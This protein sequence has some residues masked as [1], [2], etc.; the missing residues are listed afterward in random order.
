M[1]FPKQLKPID[2]PE[3]EAVKE[4]VPVEMYTISGFKEADID[5]YLRNKAQDELIKKVAEYSRRDPSILIKE[6][7]A[8][9]SPE[10]WIKA[11]GMIDS[12]PKEER[13]LL[14]IEV[15][16]KIK[17]SFAKDS[18]EVW[19]KAA[20]MINWA[21]I[22]ERASLRRDV[23]EKIKESFAK[24]NPEVWIEAIGMI[25]SAPK[26]ERA[27]LRRDVSEKIKESFSKDNPEVWIK[28]AEMINRAPEE[29]RA[30]LIKESFAKDSPEV[31]IKAAGIIYSAPEEERA[32]LIRESFA[33]DSPD[34][35]IKAAGMI[36]WAPIEERASLIRESFAK[37]SPEV[38]IK[39]A[40]MIN[41][42]P[43]EER[44]LLIKESFAK[45]SPEVWIKAAGMIDW[46]P[47]EEQSSLRRDVSEKI[48]ES[49]SKDSPELWI[50]AAGMI[51]LA[52]I[53]ERASLIREVFEKGIVEEIIKPPLY[54]NSN[55][56]DETFKREKFD[57][58]GSGTTLIGG[59]LKDKIITRHIE[60]EAFLSWQRLYEDYNL[61]KKNGFD[62]VPIEP[63]QS[64]KI[65]KDNLVD[66]HS[67]VL[68]LSLG[69]W[70]NITSLFEQELDTQKMLILET[71]ESVDIEHGHAHNDN[72]VL[73]FFRDENGK[74]DITK[75]PRLYLIDFDQAVSPEK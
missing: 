41:W 36:Y 34:A 68:D 35:W 9:D 17:E 60:P 49:F 10:L 72:F 16:E 7:F 61:W 55:I 67:G 42:A 71:L 5:K 66:V 2:E 27:L 30:L 65:G 22:E 58:T 50:K 11:A 13:A 28:A 14:R 1:E 69:S 73:R 3:K 39:A 33:K 12:A 47:I 24:D 26:E 51:D 32:S 40:E 18:P 20:E 63:I 4:A 37:D 52:P 53:E 46:A 23:S 48:K 6:Y 31:W 70:Q 74:P 56:D 54:N 43:E 44:A 45:D 8:K 19:I 62:Y 75:V 25:D 64:Y 38:W 29:E 15:S 59:S 57:K 21:P